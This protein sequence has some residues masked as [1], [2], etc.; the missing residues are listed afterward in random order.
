MS[1]GE[2]RQLFNA[3]RIVLLLFASS[4]SNV[5]EQKPSKE[6]APDTVSAVENMPAIVFSP[7]IALPS[8]NGEDPYNAIKGSGNVFTGNDV[9][10]LTALAVICSDGRQVWLRTALHHPIVVV[11]PSKATMLHLGANGHL[12]DD[13]E[14]VRCVQK[15]YKGYFNASLANS[16]TDPWTGS[17]KPFAAFYSSENN[18]AQKN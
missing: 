13:V 15:S 16:G 10:D 8:P 7:T 5:S 17:N 4:C 1:V 6:I 14:L 2:T 12:S 18:N 3:F 11:L 9:G